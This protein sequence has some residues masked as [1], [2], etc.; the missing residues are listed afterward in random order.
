MMLNSAKTS[1]KIK[2]EEKLKKVRKEFQVDNK[3]I[4]L[5]T[6]HLSSMKVQEYFYLCSFCTQN[7]MKEI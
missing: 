7:V 1:K 5:Q 4:L 3:V 6:L 2:T